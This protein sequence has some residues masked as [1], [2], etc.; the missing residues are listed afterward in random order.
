M[1]KIQI[2]KNKKIEIKTLYNRIKTKLVED[3]FHITSDVQTDYVY[4]LRAEKTGV[5]EIIIGA[6]K[7]IELI[8]AAAVFAAINVLIRPVV[9]L[10]LGPFIVLTFGLFTIVVNALM[11]YVLDIVSTPLTIDGYLPLLFATLLISVASII[12]SSGARMRFKS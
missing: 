6:V 8:I 9:K 4:H 1:T 11:L 12:A 5:T 2:V 3:N 10:F 7:D